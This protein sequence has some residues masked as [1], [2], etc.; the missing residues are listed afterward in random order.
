MSHDIEASYAAAEIARTLQSNPALCFQNAPAPQNLSTYASR[1]GQHSWPHADGVIELALTGAMASEYS[2]AVEFKRP[3]EGVHGILTAVG[4]THAYLKKGYAGAIMVVPDSYPNLNE[5]GQYLRELIE[6]TSR[7]EN[8]GVFTYAKP[9]LSNVLPFRGKI[10]ARKSFQIDSA[11]PLQPIHRLSKTSTQWAHVREGSTEPDTFFKYLQALK[12]LSGGGVAH[13][14]IVPAGLVTA[15]NTLS[16]GTDP[17]KYLSYC[18]NDDLSDRAWRHFWFKYVLPNHAL[19]G[20]TFDGANFVLKEAETAL[21]RI[22]GK[23]K[24]LFF[25]GRKNS[26][27]NK[28]VVALNA[29]TKTEAVASQELAKNYHNRAHSYREDIDS[30]CQHIGFVDNGGRLTESGYKFVDACE[31]Y[32]NPNEGVPREL[33]LNAILVDGELSAFLHYIYKLSEDVFKKDPLKFSEI[34]AGKAKFNQPEYLKYIEFEMANSL[35]VLSKST[36]RG[37]TSR[38][39]FQAELALLRSLGIVNR[40]F[41]TGVGLTIN[42]PTFHQSMN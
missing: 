6:Q 31:R 14:P 40:G 25:L 7:V 8:I 11:P 27:K 9:D 18:P 36:L 13:T 4:Q 30:G 39:P 37:G 17:E 12:H 24:K 2:I 16:P 3:N 20:W 29:G 28:L 19:D 35:S 34:I 38:K 41:R 15:V 10:T 22:D 26:I 5:T 33:F 1:E 32:G 21:D 42:W 23:G